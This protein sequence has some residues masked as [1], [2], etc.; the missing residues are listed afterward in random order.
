MD[1]LRNWFLWEDHCIMFFLFRPLLASGKCNMSHVDHDKMP[2]KLSQFLTS[3]WS[4]QD[5][6]YQQQELLTLKCCTS[7]F[8]AYEWQWTSLGNRGRWF[9]IHWFTGQLVRLV[10]HHIQLNYHH[11]RSSHSVRMNFAKKSGWPCSV[12]FNFL[13]ILTKAQFDP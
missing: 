10:V 13:T 8:V 6:Q 5:K 12:F 4:V 1:L 7:H 3:S 11:G 9:F 2:V